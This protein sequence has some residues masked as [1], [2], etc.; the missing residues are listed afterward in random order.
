MK[1][2]SST[3]EAVATAEA[4]PIDADEALPTPAP[5]A[6]VSSASVDAAIKAGTWS[7]DNPSTQLWLNSAFAPAKRVRD[8][9]VADLAAHGIEVQ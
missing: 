4:A 6:I 3:D 9:L 1:K 8:E 5:H 7:H 2:S